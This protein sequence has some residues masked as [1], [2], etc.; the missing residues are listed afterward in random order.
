MKA[1]ETTGRQLMHQ[2]PCPTACDD[3]PILHISVIDRSAPSEIISHA[4]LRP[5]SSKTK[6]VITPV[7]NFFIHQITLLPQPARSLD[8]SSIED[9]WMIVIE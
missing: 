8:L 6:H 3:R 9:V 5:Y 2:P 4:C 7:Q 1:E